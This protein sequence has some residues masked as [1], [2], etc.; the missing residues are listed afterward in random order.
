MY[1]RNPAR[2]IIGGLTGGIFLI[3]LAQESYQEGGQPYQYPSQQ[4]QQPQQ[5]Y[6]QPQAQYPQQ[7]IPPQQQ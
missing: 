4:P 3:G 5:Q 6:E 7:Q 1:Y 2:G